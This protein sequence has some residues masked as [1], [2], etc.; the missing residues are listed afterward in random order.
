MKRFYTEVTVGQDG[1]GHRVLLDGKPI[2]TPLKAPLVVPTAA[3]AA[4]LAQE[5]HAQ[6]GV[7]NPKTMPLTRHANTVIDHVTRHRAH[8]Q[9][10]IAAYA[11][12]DLLCYRA[13]A[14]TDL[15]A[16]QAASWDPWLDWAELQHAARLTVV[17][18]IMHRLQ[19]AT[20]VARLTAAVASCTDWQLAP[21][22]SLVTISGSLV[23]GLA[24]LHGACPAATAWAAAQADARYQASQWGEDAEAQEV[25]ALRAADMAAAAEFARLLPSP[26]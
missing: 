7:I 11:Q 20:A 25:A 19:P 5:W 24:V 2:R 6:T 13:D 16:A 12:S 4:A 9:A 22:H 14:P 15:V 1:S 21:L 8:V 10:E 3:L 23:L 26:S 17:T 18:G